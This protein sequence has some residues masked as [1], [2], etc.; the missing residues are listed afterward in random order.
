MDAVIPNYEG[1]GV[2]GGQNHYEV[3]KTVAESINNS[4]AITPYDSII[5][6]AFNDAVN[7][8]C[9]GTYASVDDTVNAWV[10]D[11]AGTLGEQI[12]YDNFA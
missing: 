9:V 10:D 4:G 11:V 2:L 12:G 7:E 1:L 5:K 8:Y 6:T 3:L